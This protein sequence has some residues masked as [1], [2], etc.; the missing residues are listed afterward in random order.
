MS[1]QLCVFHCVEA[2]IVSGVLFPHVRGIIHVY[3]TTADQNQRLPF[4]A[5]LFKYSTFFISCELVSVKFYLHVSW[6]PADV[7]T[8]SLASLVCPLPS[9]PLQDVP[10]RKAAQ[11]EP[12]LYHR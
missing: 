4:T 1:D 10:C 5:F 11:D 6:T 2:Y 9:P 7:S 12:G 8:A 3:Q